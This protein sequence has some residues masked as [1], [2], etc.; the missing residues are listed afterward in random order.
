MAGCTAGQ[1]PLS[2]QSPGQSL[3]ATTRVTKATMAQGAAKIWQCWP[4]HRGEVEGSS[5]ERTANWLAMVK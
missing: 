3:G 5:K 4:S 1:R 2:T